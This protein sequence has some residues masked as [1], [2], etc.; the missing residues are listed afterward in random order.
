MLVKA[1][2]TTGR[3]EYRIPEKPEPEPVKPLSDGKAKPAKSPFAE[4][5]DDDSPEANAGP[6]IYGDYFLRVKGKNIENK[7]GADPLYTISL[8]AL[9]PSNP[10]PPRPAVVQQRLELLAER[11]PRVEMILPSNDP[12]LMK[13]QVD[14]AFSRMGRRP[15]SAGE[16][17]AYAKQAAGLL[18][19]LAGRPGSPF[20]ADIPHVSTNLA[21]A[22]NTP[23]TGMAAAVALGDVPGPEAQRA[24]ADVALDPGRPP[25]LRLS[26]ANQLSRSI[27][28]FGPLLADAQEKRL[29][30]ELDREA[31]PN[32]RPASRPSLAPCG[33]KPTPSAEDC[34]PSN[35]CRTNR[36]PL[37][38]KL[39][40][41]NRTPT[42]ES[43][44]NDT[45]SYRIR[46]SGIVS[47]GP[48][49]ARFKHSKCKKRCRED[50]C[51]Y[52]TQAISAERDRVSAA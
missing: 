48:W 1:A 43:N 18:A 3:I 45:M 8:F 33:R 52:R 37:P 34:V 40:R 49:D 22:L 10:P 30:E 11:F 16:R 5:T 27:Q 32:I 35:S 2:D 36:R 25:E 9:D 21:L 4:I 17:A 31:D 42:I 6:P 29:V 44:A 28:R 24:L 23:E 7:R 46:L 51:Q 13:L 15:L 26:S 20:D 38:Q 12:N 19:F 39:P 14:R 41:P 47:R 50:G